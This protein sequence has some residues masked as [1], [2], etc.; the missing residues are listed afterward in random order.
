[1]L[2]A[3]GAWSAHFICFLLRCA[4]KPGKRAG[5]PFD[6]PWPEHLLYPAAPP[7]RR[8]SKISIVGDSAGAIRCWSDDDD[9]VILDSKQEVHLKL[10]ATQTLQVHNLKTYQAGT[11][12]DLVAG[13][14]RTVRTFHNF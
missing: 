10:Q 13:R 8:E 7:A 3:P 1:M 4:L 2:V 12:Y 11:E 6:E 5:R 14:Q 9:L